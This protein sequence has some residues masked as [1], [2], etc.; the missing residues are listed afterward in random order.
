LT[1]LGLLRL[2]TNSALTGGAVSAEDALDTLDQAISQGGHEFWAMTSYIGSVLQLVVPRIRGHRQWTD[3]Y[4]LQAA[5]ERGGIF[6]TFD[7]GVKELTTRESAAHLL[8]LKSR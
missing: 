4:L 5:V 6:V 3:A 1:Q 7:A 8:L 2:L